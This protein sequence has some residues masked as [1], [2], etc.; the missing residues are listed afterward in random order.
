MN[1]FSLKF[2][3]VVVAIVAIAC[4]MIGSFYPFGTLYA[5]LFITACGGGMAVVKHRGSL[6]V[7][8]GLA[9]LI[10][11]G[12]GFD[13]VNKSGHPVPVD[14][15]NLIQPGTTKA[16]VEA[17]LGTPTRIRRH[18]HDWIYSGST[19]CKVTIHYTTDGKVDFVDHD[20]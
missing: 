6:A 9:L 16:E 4:W 18:G 17:L 14:R 7:L 11:G 15:I 3:F 8:S 12:L 5:L 10:I 1:R 20:H 19:W 2:L 13:M